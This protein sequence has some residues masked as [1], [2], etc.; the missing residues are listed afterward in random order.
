[1]APAF[2]ALRPIKQRQNQKEKVLPR[3]KKSVGEKKCLSARRASVGFISLLC[4][5]RACF[6]ASLSSRTFATAFIRI[7]FLVST[8]V[9]SPP[10]PT[11]VPSCVLLRSVKVIS[12][13][14]EQKLQFSRAFVFASLCVRVCLCI[15]G[16]FL[17]PAQ[18]Y[19]EGR[20]T[21]V[22]EPAGNVSDQF[23]PTV[24]TNAPGRFAVQPWLRYLRWY[25]SCQCNSR[26]WKSTS[27]TTTTTTTTA[28][29]PITIVLVVILVVPV[30]R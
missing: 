27:S 15:Y 9:Q 22:A 16:L 26:L 21:G 18:A 14:S 28:T 12:E 7:K 29:H 3:K 11:T 25:H 8:K 19:G 5:S 6:I 4:V 2:P 13:I 20:V 17:W 10:H 30:L 24:E 1:M 23:V